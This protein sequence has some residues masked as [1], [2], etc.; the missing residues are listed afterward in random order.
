MTSEEDAVS[1]AL[2]HLRRL[3]VPRT[4]AK[5]QAPELL[6][7]NDVRLKLAELR[8]TTDNCK[9]TS[10]DRLASSPYIAHLVIERLPAAVAKKFLTIPEPESAVLVRE[11]SIS[12]VNSMRRLTVLD[13]SAE[14]PESSVHIDQIDQISGLHSLTADSFDGTYGDRTSLNTSYDL[15]YQGLLEPRAFAELRTAEDEMIDKLRVKVR[16]SIKPPLAQLKSCKNYVLIKCPA[17]EDDPDLELSKQFVE[18]DFEDFTVKSRAV[19]L[20]ASISY[21]VSKLV[22]IIDTM[23]SREFKLVFDDQQPIGVHLKLLTD[24]DLAKWRLLLKTL[25]QVNHIQLTNTGKL[26]V[27]PGENGD[28][29]RKPSSSWG[30]SGTSFGDEVAERA[31]DV[32]LKV[33]PGFQFDSWSSEKDRYL[34]QQDESG[35]FSSE[36]SDSHLA[37]DDLNDRARN[38]TSLA[39]LGRS[40]GLVNLLTKGGVFLK[41]GR[42]GKPHLRHVYITADLKS[43]EWRALNQP[44]YATKKRQPTANGL[45]VQLGRDSNVFRR[46]PNPAKTASSFSIIFNKRTLDLELV[47]ENLIPREVWNEA[48]TQLFEQKFNRD[49]VKRFISKKQ[50]KG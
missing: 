13:R 18:L 8:E 10:F 29:K 40:E 16:K 31:E 35:S 9:R 42:R 5:E 7:R 19:D 45:R 21:K 12:V 46:F 15:S 4:S 14:V 27:Y 47:K 33:T 48:F 43:V 39:S 49:Q 32:A 36:S 11:K 20:E 3:H 50:P 22:L 30:R 26:P 41:Y 23:G 17:Y 44:P 37:L 28:F 38:L 6:S 2:R 1:R 24:E 34:E 25:S